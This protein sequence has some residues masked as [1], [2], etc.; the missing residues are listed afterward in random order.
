MLMVPRMINA[1][2]DISDVSDLS[3]RDTISPRERKVEQAVLSW[4]VRA[5]KKRHTSEYASLRMK[6]AHFGIS[7][8]P[9]AGNTVNAF[10]T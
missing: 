6:A 4:N 9:P 2:D 3:P 1:A 5:H 8:S 7:C 10:I